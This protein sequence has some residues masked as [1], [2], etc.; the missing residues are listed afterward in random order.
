MYRNVLWRGSHDERESSESHKIS[1]VDEKMETMI[2]KIN[3]IIFGWY[4]WEFHVKPKTRMKPREMEILESEKL[5]GRSSR[6]DR[7]LHVAAFYGSL[8]AEIITYLFNKNIV[9][10]VR[11]IFMGKQ[12]VGN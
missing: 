12:R 7:K 3:K 5:Y 11:S 9:K 1:H 10:T 2:P 6:E 4:L 8:S